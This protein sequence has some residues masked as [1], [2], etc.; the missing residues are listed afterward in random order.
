M[1]SLIVYILYMSNLPRPMPHALAHHHKTCSFNV[2][3]LH[4]LRCLNHTT[5]KK[6]KLRHEHQSVFI[7]CNPMYCALSLALATKKKNQPPSPSSLS[8]S[9]LPSTLPPIIAPVLVSCSQSQAPALASTNTHT[10]THA[11]SSFSPSAR[12]AFISVEKPH[13]KKIP[14][15][16]LPSVQRSVYPDRRLET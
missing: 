2:P 7:L 10:N 9:P 13:K 1:H 8:F 16:D 6:K 11:S 15:L 3:L 14:A 5:D 4:N 12:H